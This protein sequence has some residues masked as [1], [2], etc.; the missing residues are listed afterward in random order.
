MGRI[1]GKWVK[2]IAKKLIEKYP[3]KFNNNF[4]DDKKFIESL[5]IIEDKPI[6]NKIAGYIVSEVDKRKIE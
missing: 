6:R 5:K 3:D 4:D 2:N 1:R